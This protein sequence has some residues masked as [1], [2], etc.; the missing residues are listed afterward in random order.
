MQDYLNLE[1]V[2]ETRHFFNV[3]ITWRSPTIETQILPQNEK[4]IQ[5]I[6]CFS[7]YSERILL[8]VV[9]TKS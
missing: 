9:L 2:Q 1:V 6:F 3:T 7:V 8:E 5:T 4:I